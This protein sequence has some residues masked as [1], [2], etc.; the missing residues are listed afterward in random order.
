MPVSPACAS[1]DLTWSAAWCN[2][3]SI[4][5]GATLA[6][7]ELLST[8]VDR[9]QKPTSFPNPDLVQLSNSTGMGSSVD[10]TSS[11]IENAPPG[12]LQDVVK[13]IK[14][15]TSDDDPAL[16]AKLKPAFEKYNEDQMIAVK[17]PGA[18][19]YV[20]YFAEELGTRNGSLANKT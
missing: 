17:L 10:I 16:I 13:D 19:D 12:E 8:K 7:L 2:S 1:A 11:F 15:L 9:L 5:C 4:R 3:P 18:S 14:A 20:C 6:K